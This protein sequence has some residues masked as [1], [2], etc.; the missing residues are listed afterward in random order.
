MQPI[1]VISHPRSGTHLTIDLLRRQFVGC[2]AWKWPGERNDRLYC[3][4]D[5][6]QQVGGELSDKVA[7][8]ILGR[9]PR[10]IIKSHCYGEFDEPF[11]PDRTPLDLSGHWGE[12]F[13]HSKFIY[14]WRDPVKVLES[15]F[16]FSKA[17]GLVPKAMTKTEFLQS[18]NVHGVTR[19]QQWKNHVGGWCD[20]EGILV[21]CY[22]DLLDSSREILQKLSGHI[23]AEPL[24]VEPYLAAPF[25]GVFGSRFSRLFLTRPGSTAIL[26]IAEMEPD[27]AQAE[28]TAYI[29]SET[30]NL[31][32]SLRGNN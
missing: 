32:D 13:D 17:S 22:D 24:C 28:N 21:I 20:R 16:V 30:Q 19:V 23:E 9:S 26:N 6:L 1:V 11:F 18:P 10:P 31:T 29:L 27:K 5:E 12:I 25:K 8:R 4:I 15:L 14:V 2:S 3:N 7:L